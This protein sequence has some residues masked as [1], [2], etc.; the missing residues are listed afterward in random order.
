MR[1]SSGTVRAK[2]LRRIREMPL[3]RITKPEKRGDQ[4]EYAPNTRVRNFIHAVRTVY[5]VRKLDLIADMIQYACCLLHADGCATV[6]LQLYFAL[7]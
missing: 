5:R 3:R 2:T 4:M 7:S 6:N 1:I